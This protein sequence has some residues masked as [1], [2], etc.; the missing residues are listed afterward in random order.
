MGLLEAIE[1]MLPVELIEGSNVKE[2]AEL[3]DLTVAYSPV[4]EE[5]LHN[6]P[7]TT[8]RTTPPKPIRV[9]K[10]GSRYCIVDAK[11]G[12]Y[13]WVEPAALRLMRARFLLLHGMYYRRLNSMG[14]QEREAVLAWY[15]PQGVWTPAPG[16]A[17][18]KAMGMA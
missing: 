13:R 1:K 15:F 4:V 8:Y 7:A 2:V 6:D 11:A 18:A 17:L 12:Y 3:V 14:H 9:T 5:V 16:S 10:D